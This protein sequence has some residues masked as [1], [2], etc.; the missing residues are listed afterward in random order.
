MVEWHEVLAAVGD[1]QTSDRDVA[2]ARLT[3]LWEGTDLPA[4]RCV[5][6]HFLADVQDSLDS[7]VAWDEA[8]WVAFHGV[9]D[10]DLEPIGVPSAAGFEPSLHLNL[11]DGY[12][13]QG[14]RDDASR[15]LALARAAL[16]SMGDDGYG[17]MVRRGLHGL[18]A[19]LGA[20]PDV[21][22]P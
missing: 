3:G 11:G 10:A 8:A 7:E 21:S 15:E 2:R 17:A 12:L 4:Q 5:I 1:A 18:E 19:R 6:A 20:L 16:A 13:R 9:S 22:S 14:R